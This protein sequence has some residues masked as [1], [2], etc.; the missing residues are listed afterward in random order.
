MLEDIYTMDKVILDFTASWC[1]PCKRI[2]PHFK[3][4]E[5]EYPNINFFK[6]DV[7]EHR[8]IASEFSITAMPTFVIL[9][10]GKEVGRVAGCDE[11]K[12][13]QLLEKLDMMSSE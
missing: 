5:L 9:H 8:E 3:K 13:K 2:A 12:L 10:K 4:F 11:Y 7:D 6:V 1:G